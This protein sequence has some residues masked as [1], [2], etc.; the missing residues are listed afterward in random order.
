VLYSSIFFISYISL[1]LS[2][3]HGRHMTQLYY[4][5]A[6][7][8]LRISFPFFPPSIQHCSHRP[9]SSPI[10]THLRV[11]SGCNLFF[12]FYFQGGWRHLGS[13]VYIIYLALNS[14]ALSFYFIF[15][16][17]DHSRRHGKMIKRT[18]RFLL[19]Y[20][21][22]YLFIYFYYEEI[23]LHIRSVCSVLSLVCGR[24]DQLI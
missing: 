19:G 11:P 9:A 23:L 15:L 8:A 12:S 10:Q 4:T 3:C 14:I 18:T 1:L 22:I 21:C 2:P 7:T 20:V 6:Y 13:V 24:T 16:F 5:G 17:V